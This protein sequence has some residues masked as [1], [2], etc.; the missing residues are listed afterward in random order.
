MSLNPFANALRH[1]REYVCLPCRLRTSSTSRWQR[2]TQN[3]FSTRLI[4]P[5]LSPAVAASLYGEIDKLDGKQKIAKPRKRETKAKSAELRALSGKGKHT[6]SK[7]VCIAE[8]NKVKTKGC[9]PAKKIP[10][11]PKPLVPASKP[12]SDGHDSPK[13]AKPRKFQRRDTRHV[14]EDVRRGSELLQ[15][16]SYEETAENPTGEHT[17]D[18][19]VVF[20]KRRKVGEIRAKRRAQRLMKAR[21]NAAFLEQNAEQSHTESAESFSVT[22]KDVV[23]DSSQTG[24]TQERISDSTPVDD[25]MSNPASTG[26]RSSVA[27]P[28]RAKILRYLSLSKL[29]VRKIRA[30]SLATES[31]PT[32][33]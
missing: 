9:G 31:N 18:D 30:S 5:T 10:S 26:K 4:L 32:V 15:T 3:A 19:P 23:S 20:G 13:A 24:P 27:S 12:Q 29:R 28:L 7:E 17:T 6:P 33:A 16:E 8:P 11:A 25:Q 2:P 21:A 1:Q 14:K 22:S